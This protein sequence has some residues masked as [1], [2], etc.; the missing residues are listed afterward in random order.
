MLYVSHIVADA[1]NVA[2]AMHDVLDYRIIHYEEKMWLMDF[3]T[4]SEE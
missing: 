4:E 2:L 1:I 3:D